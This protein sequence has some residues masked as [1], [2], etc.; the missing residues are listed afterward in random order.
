MTAPLDPGAGEERA[1]RAAASRARALLDHVL[2]ASAGL[3]AIGAL[4]ISAY[5]AYLTRQ[6]A[7][8][9][10]WPYVTQGNTGRPVGGDGYARL[11]ANVGL[12][13][14]LVRRMRIEI[15]AR[16]A[17]DWREVFLRGLRTDSARF[18]ARFGPDMRTTTSTVARG[19]VLLPGA[20]TE[21]LRIPAGPFGAEVRTL[22]NDRRTRIRICYCSL[23]DDCWWSDSSAAEPTPVDACPPDD[24]RD[25]SG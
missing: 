11:V 9:S 2:S 8:M 6:Q 23:Y 21:I 13:P 24:G 20:T 1:A 5:Q 19:M 16:P 18:V 4:A 3:V 15:D 10:A 17:A 25:F 12:G 22:L 14:A 7:K